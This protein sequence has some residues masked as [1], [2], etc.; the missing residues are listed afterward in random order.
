MKIRT[1]LGLVAT[2]LVIVALLA[3]GCGKEA[4]E[5]STTESAGET[6]ESTETA[7]GAREIEVTLTDF[8]IEPA[9]IELKSGETVTFVVKNNGATQHDFAI[10]GS[11]AKTPM[12]DAGGEATLEYTPTA[13]GEVQFI[14]SVPGH[15]VLG[16]TGT[17]TVTE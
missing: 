17:L 15:D 2:G 11:D 12:I 7:T 10:V 6:T 1:K 3:A 13:A 8:A 14:C 5:G 4:E 9:S 16:M